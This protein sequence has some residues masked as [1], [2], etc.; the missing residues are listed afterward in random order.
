MATAF[1]DGAHQG[2]SPKSAMSLAMAG[3]ELPE[4]EMTPALMEAYLLSA[5]T[6]PEPK[7]D[8]SSYDW[9]AARLGGFILRTIR[10]H[11]E[12]ATAP[13]ESV[14]RFPENTVES[15]VI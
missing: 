1:V 8:A 3:G 14:V 7:D 10:D 2:M 6:A 12:I 15:M 5:W 11:P 4:Q 13:V 9:G